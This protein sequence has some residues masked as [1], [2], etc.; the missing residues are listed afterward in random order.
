MKKIN[1]RMFVKL[2][3][4]EALFF[5]SFTSCIQGDYYD[6]YDN[7]DEITIVRKKN[8]QDIMPEDS[9][10]TWQNGECATWALLC[11]YNCSHLDSQ[12][13]KNQVINAL[14]G[15][16]PTTD[17]S[18]S[19]WRQYNA[20]IQTP[21]NPGGFSKSAIKSAGL[22]LSMSFHDSSFS[23]LGIDRNN[24]NKSLSGVIMS[25]GNHVVVA[26][27]Y[28]KK[29]DELVVADVFTYMG[30]DSDL[31]NQDPENGGRSNSRTI[32]A[33]SIVWMIAL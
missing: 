18:A 29:T 12:G 2:V 24:K 21:S 20:A 16:E 6:L 25:T 32:S 1:Y 28:L 33:S 4:V 14:C 3:L 10:C 7:L 13:Y 19:T 5:A 31:Q 17:V 15:N 11:L 30:F 26:D 23:D 8:K 9:Y 27:R 22:K